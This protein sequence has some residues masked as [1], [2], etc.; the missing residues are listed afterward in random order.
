[1]TTTLTVQDGQAVVIGGLIRQQGSRNRTG[2]PFLSKIPVVGFMF[3][4]RNDQIDKDELLLMI[5][6]HVITSADEADVVTE[7]FRNK[8][9]EVKKRLDTREEKLK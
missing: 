7:E 4:Y 3:G 2:V 1:A 6:P 9:E 8:V 5:T